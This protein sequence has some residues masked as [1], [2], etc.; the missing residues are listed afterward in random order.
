[1]NTE[2]RKSIRETMKDVRTREEGRLKLEI[3]DT[4]ALI[5]ES[6]T[7]AELAIAEALADVER[8]DDRD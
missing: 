5:K 4:L 2:L 3:L 8:A 7:S 1:M 6:L